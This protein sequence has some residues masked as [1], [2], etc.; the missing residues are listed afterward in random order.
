M[1]APEPRGPRH[2]LVGSGPGELHCP[3]L[4]GGAVA[5]AAVVHEGHHREAAGTIRDRASVPARRCVPGAEASLSRRGRAAR[6]VSPQVSAENDVKI[7]VLT[8]TFN[9]A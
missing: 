5:D 9:A 6:G 4:R 2:A 8:P 3:P 7:D 1:A